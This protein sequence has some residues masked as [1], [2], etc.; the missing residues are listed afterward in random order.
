M[1]AG[2]V[3]RCEGVTHVYPDT[4]GT[5]VVALDAVDLEVAPGQA[6]ALVGPSGSGKSTLLTVLAGL[7]RP[8]AGRVSVAGTD[9]GGLTERAL[10][11][12]R[13]RSLGIVLQTP[14][15][16]LLPY[17]SARRNVTFAQR[18]AGGTRA[19][20]G[21]EVDGL[22]EAVGLLPWAGTAARHLSGGQQQRLALAV[23]L[24]GDP[25]L[26]LADEPTSQLDRATGEVVLELMVRAREERGTALVVVTHDREVSRR[27]DVEHTIHDGRLT[28]GPDRG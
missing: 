27:L 3:V 21:R 16:N 20:R 28:S 13:A 26:L 14:G 5:E 15:R 7:V 24:A 10:L 23:A 17:A 2:P 6:V 11:G 25:P 22:L 19:E 9:L 18:S 12:V 8:T 1:S 4:D